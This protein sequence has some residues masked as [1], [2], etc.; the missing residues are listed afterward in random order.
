MGVLEFILYMFMTICVTALL[1]QVINT[2]GG[3]HKRIKREYKNI[4]E[5]K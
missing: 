4:K 2:L 5:D 3:L 1:S